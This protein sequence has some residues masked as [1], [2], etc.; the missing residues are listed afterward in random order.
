MEN[1]NQIPQNL[2][3][4]MRVKAICMGKLVG[5]YIV[6]RIDAG[7]AYLLVRGDVSKKTS[8][9]VSSSINSRNGAV[10]CLEGNTIQC[11]EYYYES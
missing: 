6:D 8:K 10:E 4:G 7:K 3:K 2:K 11:T 9:V 5:D 1:K